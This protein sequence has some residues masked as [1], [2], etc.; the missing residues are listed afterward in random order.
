[1]AKLR[2]KHARAQKQKASKFLLAALKNKSQM[3]MNAS[4]DR[5]WVRHAGLQS[6]FTF[7]S[8]QA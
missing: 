7:L 2:T 3:R 4:V 6:V 1:M 8:K 5:F